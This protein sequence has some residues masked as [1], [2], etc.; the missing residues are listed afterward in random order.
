MGRRW[1]FYAYPSGE[2][3]G[4]FTYIY[5]PSRR[6]GG[7]GQHPLPKPG[8]YWMICRGPGFFAIVW[9]SSSP[10]RPH[11]PSPFSICSIGDTQEDW[12]R[13]TTYRRER[14][15]VIYKTGRI[16]LPVWRG[17]HRHQGIFVTFENNR[18]DDEYKRQKEIDYWKKFLK[19]LWHCPFKH[20]QG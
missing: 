11:P 5:P 18:H 13:E 14:R 20:P 4:I 19:I 12:E 9:F 2:E 3:R 15:E 16:V 7:G 1:V 8:E 10:T 6:L 17:Y